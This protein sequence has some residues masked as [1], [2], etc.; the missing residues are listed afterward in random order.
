MIVNLFLCIDSVHVSGRKK[1]QTSYS[2][3]KPDMT[4]GISVRLIV[5]PSIFTVCSTLGTG[6]NSSTKKT[7]DN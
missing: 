4:W 2:S 3:F 6:M 5:S 1:L 7:N